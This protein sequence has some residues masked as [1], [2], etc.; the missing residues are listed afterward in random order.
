MLD[1]EVT[2]DNAAD[3]ARYVLDNNISL[4]SQLVKNL[5]KWWKSCKDE[6]RIYHGIYDC[7]KIQNSL[8]QGYPITY[9]SEKFDIN[10]NVIKKNIQNNQ[11]S[12]QLWKKNKRK[13]KSIKYYKLLKNG[14]TITTGTLKEI[15]LDTEIKQ[16]R[17]NYYRAEHYGI[18]YSLR[19]IKTE[20]KW[21]KP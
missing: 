4:D 11:L 6:S 19:Y 12:D 17:L 14:I 5:H 8:N 18:P 20:V 9:I 2:S 3:L 13:K 7:I 10:P 15:S 21:I 16:K 1:V